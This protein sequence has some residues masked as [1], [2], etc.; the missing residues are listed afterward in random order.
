MRAMPGASR[1]EVK[2]MNHD[3]KHRE[4]TMEDAPRAIMSYFLAP[5]VG[6][7]WDKVVGDGQRATP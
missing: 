4:N 7:K 1:N 5:Q 3:R 2:R 6:S